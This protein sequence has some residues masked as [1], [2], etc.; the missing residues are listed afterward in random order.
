M[1]IEPVNI[2]KSDGNKKCRNVLVVRYAEVHVLSTVEIPK[3][4]TK[5]TSD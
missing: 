4:V 1:L 2:S 5:L 3:T